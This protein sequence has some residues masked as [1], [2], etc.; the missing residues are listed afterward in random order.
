M[1]WL[2][3]IRNVEKRYCYASTFCVID[4]ESDHAIAEWFEVGGPAGNLEF[5]RDFWVRGI[6]KIDDTERIDAEERDDV[7]AVAVETRGVKLFT[8]CETKRAD[9]DR[10]ARV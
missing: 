10:R 9:F 3:D 2:G 5:T 7:S 8:L 6:G 4:A 1:F